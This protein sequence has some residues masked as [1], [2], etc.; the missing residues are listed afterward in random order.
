M[1]ASQ[2]Y[3]IAKFIDDPRRM[4][5]RNI[6][7]MLWSGG[8]VACRFTPAESARFIH[9]KA[10]Y[11]RWVAFWTKQAE[12]PE[13]KSQSGELVSR[14]TSQFVDAL[15]LSQK[16][17]YRLYEAGYL[18]ERLRA[19]EREEAV[20]FL[21]SE[22]VATSEAIEEEKA[23]LPL[24]DTCADLFEQAGAVGRQEYHP[25][26]RINCSVEGVW[27]EF[28]FDYA[29]ESRTLESVF[30]RVL[31]SGQQSVFAATLMFEW[32][33]KSA[34]VGVHKLRKERCFSLINSG[35]VNTS[36]SV[37]SKRLEMLDK[38]STLVDVADYGNAVEQ[39]SRATVNL[40]ALV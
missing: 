39:I 28:R 2:R 34:T 20:E 12:R 16:G 14:R 27:Q 10:T 3:L 38:F 37:V 5:P 4:E 21:Y 19:G 30:Q 18:P 25:N 31:L 7:V 1:S 22:L 9:D 35:D 32:L 17:N 15:A 33:E 24:R 29:W 26:F 11:Q 13:L 8:K 6:G 40:S 36:D 23:V